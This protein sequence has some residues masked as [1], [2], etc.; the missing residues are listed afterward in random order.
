MM[1]LTEA[2]KQMDLLNEDTFEITNDG[3]EKLKEFENQEFDDDY[4]EVIDTEAETEDDI[5]D[6]YI[7]QV[8]LDCNVCHSKLYK[9]KEDVVVEEENANIEEECPFCYSTEGFKVIGEVA[10]YGEQSE[11]VEETEDEI[12]DETKEETEDVEVEETENEIDESLEKE[13]LE[14]FIGA[15]NGR[16]KDLEEM[17]NESTWAE[18]EVAFTSSTQNKLKIIKDADLWDDMK[19]EID[20]NPKTTNIISGVFTDIYRTAKQEYSNYTDEQIKDARKELF[21]IINKF[22]NKASSKDLEE[23]IDD[24][25]GYNIIKKGEFFNVTDDNDVEL[26][27]D[28]E[29]EDAA[30]EYIKTIDDKDLNESKSINENINNLSLDTE[31]THMEMTSDET[32]KVTITTEPLN[33]VEDSEQVIAPVSD[34]TEADILDNGE[35]EVTDETIEDETIDMDMEEFD[36]ES[37]DE[38]GEAYFKEAYNNVEEF[39]TTDVSETEDGMLVE[40]MLKFNSG[41]CKK[42]SFLFE[43]NTV[44]KSNKVRLI[45]ENK[46]LKSG[47]E[48]FIVEGL[49]QDKKLIS[50]SLEYKYAELN[51]KVSR[52]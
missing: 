41:N 29:S 21:N 34:E 38:L 26:D 23:S 13:E 50:E 37:F 44:D 43:S 33:N 30:K 28:F 35:E 10:P 18:K 24:L 40:G 36:E 12:E 9:N 1:Q 4:V 46:E 7:G 49:L 42:T 19:E 47:K 31:D 17:L 2:F 22:Y 39:K 52:G 3:L 27:I 16:D 48:S 20:N 45:G 6:S 11:E 14:Q 5:N 25:K 51:G 8:I 15:H 32:G